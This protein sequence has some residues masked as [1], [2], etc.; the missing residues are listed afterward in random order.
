MADGRLEVFRR[1]FLGRGFFA[2]VAP[3]TS[4]PG[5]AS[6]I[7]ESLVSMRCCSREEFANNRS[8]HSFFIYIDSLIALST[9]VCKLCVP[10]MHRWGTIEYKFGVVFDD[11]TELN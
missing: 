5:V 6:V 9:H 7:W 3:L 1:A 11:A 4:R 8:A 2:H 10:C